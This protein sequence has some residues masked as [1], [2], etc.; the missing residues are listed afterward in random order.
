MFAV[1]PIMSELSRALV[2]ANS[3]EVIFMNY[4]IGLFYPF[5]NI[6]VFNRI[7]DHALDLPIVGFKSFQADD[8]YTVG[9]SNLFLLLS[10]FVALAFATF[11]A[12]LQR[13]W[14]FHHIEAIIE[15]E[16]FAGGV[17]LPVDKV[18]PFKYPLS[19]SQ[20]TNQLVFIKMRLLDHAG[21]HFSDI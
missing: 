8:E 4:H 2:K 9:L 12:I 6:H 11:P 21:V 13:L 1:S 19:P 10:S 15:G 3:I 7:S 17:Q 14:L 16:C 5:G 18:T 20:I